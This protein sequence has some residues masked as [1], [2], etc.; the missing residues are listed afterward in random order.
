M[1]AAQQVLRV[2]EAELGRDFRTGGQG[3]QM[4]RHPLFLDLSRLDHWATGDR[5]YRKVRV[6]SSRNGDQEEAVEPRGLRLRKGQLAKPR[7]DNALR[8]LQPTAEGPGFGG[9]EL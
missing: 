7:H 9:V 5:D 3:H 4:V 1:Q 6:D 8:Q 2:L